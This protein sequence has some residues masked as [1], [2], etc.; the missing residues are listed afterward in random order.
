MTTNKTLAIDVMF[1]EGVPTLVGVN[2]LK[3]IAAIYKFFNRLRPKL[4]TKEL[5]LIAFDFT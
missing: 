1:V 2:R 5:H 4:A 3:F